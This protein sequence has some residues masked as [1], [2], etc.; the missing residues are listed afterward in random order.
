MKVVN[1]FMMH[2]NVLDKQTVTI[3]TVAMIP[4]L[5]KECVNI[6]E[7]LGTMITVGAVAEVAWEEEE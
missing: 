7:D 3:A 1:C 6:V 4:R 5:L 2:Y